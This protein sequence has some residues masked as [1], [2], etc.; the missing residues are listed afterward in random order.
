M[1][2]PVFL[3]YVSGYLRRESIAIFALGEASTRYVHL[4]EY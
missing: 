1:D 4:S 3:V 2:S